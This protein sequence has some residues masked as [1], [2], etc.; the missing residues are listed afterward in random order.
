[1][2]NRRGAIF[3]YPIPGL[4]ARYFGNSEG[5]WMNL[6]MRYDLEVQRER[7]GEEVLKEISSK[8]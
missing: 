1:M 8:R 7:I 5:F 2:E 3:H 4:L 6:Q